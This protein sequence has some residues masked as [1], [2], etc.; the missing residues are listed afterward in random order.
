MRRPAWGRVDGRGTIG[1]MALEL[2]PGE[3]LV[4]TTR[5]HARTL[6]WPIVALF[7]ISALVGAGIAVI[8]A[9]YRPLGQ[10]IVVA[11][12]A[13]ASAITVLRPVLRRSATSVTLTTQRLIVRTGLVRRAEHEIPLNRVVNIASTRALPD[14]GFG[15]GTLLLTTL[16]GQ[17]LRLTHMP[18]IKAMRQAVSELSAQSR[19]ELFVDPWRDTQVL[20]GSDPWR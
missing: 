5:P 14:F 6:F 3:E 15:T 7:A 13:L 19:P 18:Q 2:Y 1:V 20:G 17:Q 11:L 10:Q 12:G 8:P 9:D 16:G 4:T